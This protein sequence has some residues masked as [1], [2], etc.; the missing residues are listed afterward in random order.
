[1]HILTKLTYKNP[2]NSGKLILIFLLTKCFAKVDGWRNG[3]TAQGAN[4]KFAW[5]KALGRGGVTQT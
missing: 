4:V 1:M 3:K 2:S 5:W